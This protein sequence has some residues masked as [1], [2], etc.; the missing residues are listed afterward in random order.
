MKTGKELMSSFIWFPDG[1]HRHFTFFYECSVIETTSNRKYGISYRGQP[2]LELQRYASNAT[3]T[4]N[5]LHSASDV[6]HFNVI[7]G[8]SNGH[9]LIAFF[10]SAVADR[11]CLGMGIL[12]H[13]DTVIMDNCGFHQRCFIEPMVITKNDL[14]LNSTPENRL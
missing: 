11:N 5:L 3:Y 13:G 10:E 6:D 2:A 12:L 4:I 14:I 9:E 1:Q 7:P 8:A